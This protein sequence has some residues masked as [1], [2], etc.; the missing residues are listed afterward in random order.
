MSDRMHLVGPY[1][2]AIFL[3]TVSLLRRLEPPELATIAEYARE[4]TFRKGDVL[5]R[6][7]METDA[8]FVVV[9]GCVRVTGAEHPGGKVLK[10]E[11]TV[12]LLSLLARSDAGVDAVAESDGLALEIGSDLVMDLFEEHFYFLLDVLKTL[13]ASILRERK[14]IPDGSF[15]GEKEPIFGKS[16]SELDLVNVIVFM[17]SGQTFRNASLDTLVTLA[18]QIK[19]ERFDAGHVL[20]RPGDRSGFMHVILSGRVRCEQEDGRGTFHCGTGYP[21]GNL[22]SVAGEPRWYTAVAETEV[23]TFRNE[24]ENLLD[25]MEDDMQLGNEFL[26]AFARNLIR[27]RGE[28]QPVSAGAA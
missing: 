17:S 13:A 23:F 26:A 4:R 27:V 21:L 22:E 25:L 3:R 1:E 14:C 28:A 5:L 6:R 2:R 7:G 12:G 15:L 16:E 20:W 11:D 9:D 19:R 10:G 24:T 18:R 8:F